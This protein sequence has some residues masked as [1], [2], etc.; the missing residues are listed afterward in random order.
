MPYTI[1]P[2]I[3]DEA[4]SRADSLRQA[5]S[6][7]LWQCIIELY[8]SL[9]RVLNQSDIP[10]HDQSLFPT[11]TGAR[12]NTIDELSRRIMDEKDGPDSIFD[13]TLLETLR[14]IIDFA[15]SL[16]DIHLKHR[17]YCVTIGQVRPLN[18]P[19]YGLQGPLWQ[20]SVIKKTDL[21]IPNTP[22]GLFLFFYTPTWM[23]MVDRHSSEIENYLSLFMSRYRIRADIKEFRWCV[24]VYDRLVRMKSFIQIDTTK[25]DAALWVNNVLGDDDGTQQV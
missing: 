9:C 11:D 1:Q 5:P 7:P 18:T 15:T 4:V 22:P 23:E 3:G 12:A 17:R 25:Y 10:S 19:E 16:S 2:F 13:G 24:K 6:A 20:L 21:S 14:S 8:H